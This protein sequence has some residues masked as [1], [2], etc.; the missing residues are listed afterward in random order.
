[1]TDLQLIDQMRLRPGDTIEHRQ[2]FPKGPW[3]EYR[4]TLLWVGNELAVWEYST[5]N[6][7]SLKWSEPHE[8]ASHVGVRTEDWPED[9]WQKVDVHLSR[10]EEN[11]HV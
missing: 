11:I 5:R 1:M 6:N 10:S 7:A 4:R 8:C 3:A 9:H 2:D